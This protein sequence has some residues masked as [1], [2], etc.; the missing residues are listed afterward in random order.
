MSTATIKVD[1]SKYEKPI[2]FYDEKGMKIILY[3]PPNFIPDSVDGRYIANTD[4]F[5][6]CL[7]YKDR[8]DGAVLFEDDSVRFVV[9]RN[10]KKLLFILIKNV[11]VKKINQIVLEQRIK[12]DLLS[13][14]NSAIN[15]VSKTIE[16]TN[17]E[18]TK[19]ILSGA[20]NE[21]VGATASAS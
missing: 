13:S 15:K 9:G 7:N 4:S 16:K 10:T 8:E 20:V 14:F 6:I 12:Q 3:I 11:E 2:P 5:E 19:T 18:V 21:L 1:K 17:L